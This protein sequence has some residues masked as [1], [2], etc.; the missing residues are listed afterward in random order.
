MTPAPSLTLCIAVYRGGSYWKECWDSVKG[1]SHY[2][3]SILISFNKSELQMTDVSVLLADK[4]ENVTYLVQQEYLEPMAHHCEFIKHVNSDYVFFLCHD[5]WLLESGLKEIQTILNNNHSKMIAI[6]GSHEW[7]GS[8]TTCS[9]ITREL[10]AYPSGI[11]V[12]DFILRDIDN[13]FNFSISGLVSPAKGLKEKISMR[14]LFSKGFRYDN[15]VITYPGIERIFQT[16]QPSVRI[17][18]HPGQEGSQGYPE[19]RKFDNMSYFFIQCLCGPDENFFMNRTV[20]KIIRVTGRGPYKGTI[21]HFLNMIIESRH[22]GIT[23]RKYL[24][25][26]LFFFRLSGQKTCV[27]FFRIIRSVVRNNV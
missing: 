26:G 23:P 27:Y 8:E 25:F 18:L 5:D 9:G 16:Q 10:L 15:F 3:D 4:P 20:D 22:W 11:P 1:L 17:R 2:F 13:S 19:E 21:S 12:H 7:S 24:D 6:F 14:K